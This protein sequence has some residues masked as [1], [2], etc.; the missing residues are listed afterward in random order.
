MPEVCHLAGCAMRWHSRWGAGSR[1]PP[2]A[3]CLLAN[4]GGHTT[5]HQGAEDAWYRVAVE[6]EEM[7]LKGVKYCGGTADIMKFVDQ[8]VREVVYMLAEEG[9]MPARV[10]GACKSF[11]E[12]LRVYNSL[13]EGIGMP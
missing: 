7:R 6:V 10:L 13:A 11:Q 2:R 3:G 12:G 5:G 8:V 1:Q 9:G 4:A